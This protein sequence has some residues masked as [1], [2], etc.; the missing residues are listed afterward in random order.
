[1]K[2][3]IVTFNSI[4]TIVKSEESE[5]LE[6]IDH[7]RLMHCT[8]CTILPEDIRQQCKT[9]LDLKFMRMDEKYRRIEELVGPCKGRSFPS[10]VEIAKEYDNNAGNAA[11]AGDFQPFVGEEKKLNYKL[12]CSNLSFKQD[13]TKM[14]ANNS[15]FYDLV[16]KY[17][18]RDRKTF[19][20][21]PATDIMEL[22]TDMNACDF[23]TSTKL[24][25]YLDTKEEGRLWFESGDLKP[26]EDKY[27]KMAMADV[28]KHLFLISN[29]T[30]MAWL[31]MSTSKGHTVASTVKFLLE[32]EHAEEFK[33]AREEIKDD[34]EAKKTQVELDRIVKI[35]NDRHNDFDMHIIK[36]NL[37]I[38]LD[39]ESDGGTSHMIDYCETV[40]CN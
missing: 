25:F 12:R 10:Y 19:K 26:Q 1:M 22:I 34:A 14:Y 9:I 36:E 33:T 40:L 17:I 7:K 39:K 13:D 8:N 23:A 15:K 28:F 2:Q 4:T 37:S 38:L 21:V 30:E 32:K 3:S 6:K 35:L 11:P 31:L 29:P 18:V 5:L 20:L 27:I 24:G 16:R